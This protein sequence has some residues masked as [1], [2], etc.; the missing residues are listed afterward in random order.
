MKKLVSNILQWFRSLPTQTILPAAEKIGYTTLG[1]LLALWVNNCDEGRKKLEIEQRTL[2]EIRAGLMQDQKDL[3]ETINGYQFRVE[4]IQNIFSFL[5]R[6]SIPADSLSTAISSLN[7]YSYLLANTA[8]YETLKSRGLETITKDSLRLSIATLYDVEYEAI[9]TSE[10][11]LD[12]IFNNLLLPH[13]M[14]NI[15]LGKERFLP[16]EIEAI[17]KDRPFQQILWQVMSMNSNTKERYI[18]ALGSLQQLLTEIEK[19][20]NSGRF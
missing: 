2:L 13:L 3:Q 10:R 16:S 17:R 14:H 15:R 9:Q 5:S 20:L 1:I 11:H 18:S 6:D 12:E 19:E 4:N 8:A 7:G